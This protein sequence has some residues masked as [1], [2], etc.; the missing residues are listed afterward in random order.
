MKHIKRLAS[1]L[2][3]LVMTLA[4]AVP[5][6]AASG[7]YTITINKDTNGH[8]Y[9]AYQ[10]FAGDLSTKDGNK[11]LSNIVW[12]D[13][14][15]ETGKT[16]LLSFNDNSYT[17][18]AELADA[19][20]D[21]NVKKFAQ[22]AAGYLSGTKA[23]SVFTDGKY[24]ISELAAGYYLIKDVAAPEGDV[25]SA[26]MLQVVGNAVAQPKDD[27]PTLDK[28][29]KNGSDWEDATG[30]QI[31]DTVEFRT[32]TTVPDTT[33]YTKYTY[34]IHDTMSD[35][36]TS[37]VKG[38]SNVTIKVNDETTLDSGYYVVAVDSNNANKFSVTIN[39]LKAVEDGKIKAGD[40]LYTYYTGVLNENA[41]I[42]DNKEVNTAKLE[43]SNNPNGDSTSK[44]TESKVYVWTFQMGVNKVDSKSAELTGAT[45][46]LSKDGSLNVE[47]LNCTDGTP[48]VT[49]D[50]IA[51]VEVSAG[52]YRVAV[53]GD[54]N[55]TYVIEAGNVTITGLDDD[56]YYLYETKAP[57]GYNLLKEPV[58]V[59]I[60]A[61]YGTD[62]S[63]CTETVKVNGT[64]TSSLTVDVVNNAGAELPST[65]GMGTTIFYIVGG[66]LVVAAVVLLVTKKRMNAEK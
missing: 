37:N 13:G 43:F 65:G 34:T 62:G 23:T 10:I 31:G 3:A 60:T 4:L 54:T 19:L 16:A 27:K 63:T 46:V 32:I 25:Y 36:L 39:I 53:K 9:E 2:L 58:K 26:Y 41:K 5:A 24:T 8:T 45:F 50:L 55:T 33:G 57:E 35:G 28:E 18:A 56:T 1:V 61:E 40:K 21:S 17:D 42:Y 38:A 29:V 22:A 7:P 44:T 6:M 52:N 48:S 15:T 12:G 64:E 49:D 47:D 51:L 30:V 11:I 14:V 20:T 59:E 66:V